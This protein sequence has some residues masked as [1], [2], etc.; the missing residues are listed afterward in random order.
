MR[1]SKYS[2]AQA[3]Y[4]TKKICVC[5]FVCRNMLRDEEN[6]CLFV[7]RNTLRSEENLCL[8]VCRKMLRYEENLCLFVSCMSWSRAVRQHVSLHHF[9]STSGLSA[10]DER[11][12]DDIRVAVG[13][14]RENH[15]HTL[16]GAVF[17]GSNRRIGWNVSDNL[18]KMCAAPWKT[19]VV[20][21]WLRKIAYGF[22][23]HELVFGGVSAV[24]VYD[25]NQDGLMWFE[26][27]W[28]NSLWHQIC[29][30]R[31]GLVNW[32][33]WLAWRFY[34]WLRLDVCHRDKLWTAAVPESRQGRQVSVGSLGVLAR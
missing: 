8:F 17:Q 13:G 15:I 22:F 6:L 19:D 32:R 23:W 14:A 9:G 24:R 7:C 26:K 34:L 21:T 25:K 3:C 10:F 33:L 18:V 31:T 5:L 16:R 1:V 4:G 28:A 30:P 20:G 11:K 2:F 29:N 12:T 27:I